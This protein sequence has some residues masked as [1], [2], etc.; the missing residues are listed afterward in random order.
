MI[1]VRTFVNNASFGAYAAW[2]TA[3]PTGTT[4]PVRRW[5][6][7]PDLLSGHGGRGWPPTPTGRV[8]HPQA[9][10]VSDNPYGTGDVAG[11]GRRA[12][13]DSGKLGLV[14]VTAG[15]AVQAVGLLRGASSRRADRGAVPE[16]VVT[17][18]AP[19]IPVGVDGEA[20]LLPTPVRCTIRPRALRVRVPRVR[21]GCPGPPGAPELGGTAPASRRPGRHR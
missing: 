8:D 16:V 21:P 17:A 10:L 18:D 5:T 4:R 19:Q 11:M 12:R 13:L 6:L 7:L 9:V 1:A 2:S 15:D 14:T 20:L 3:R